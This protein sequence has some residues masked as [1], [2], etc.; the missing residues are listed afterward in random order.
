VPLAATDGAFDEVAEAVSG[1]LPVLTASC[2]VGT[3]TVWVRAVDA[4][5]HDTTRSFVLDVPDIIFADGFESGDL[6]RWSATIGPTNLA[7]AGTAAH[8]GAYGLAVSL[9]GSTKTGVR[10]TTPTNEPSYHARFWFHPHGSNLGP[11]AEKIFLGKSASGKTLFDVEVQ[12]VTGGYRIRAFALVAKKEQKSTWVALSNGWHDIEIGWR[13]AASGGLTLLVDGS[14]VASAAGD[15]S[16]YT[17]DRVELGAVGGLKSGATGT[18]FFDSFVST[19]AT[20]IGPTAASSWSAGSP[21]RPGPITA[22]PTRP[23]SRRW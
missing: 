4:A 8:D 5:G 22:G 3:Q 15:T 9:A 18:Q 12:Q 6:S 21:V 23:E 2:G 17:L 19:R 20:T 10:D 14:V 11:A 13:S 1:S 7:V 16:A